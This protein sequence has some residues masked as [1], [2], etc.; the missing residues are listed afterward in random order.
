MFRP[1][2]LL[3]S[4][5]FKIEEEIR[6]GINANTL[7]EK[8]TL[9]ERHLRRLFKFAFKQT[10]AGYIR[11]R[12]LATSL[13]D[14]LMTDSN[15]LNIALEYNFEYEHTYIRSFKSEF[16]ITPGE[17]RKSG[18]IVRI[19][20][21]LYLLDENNLDGDLLFGPDIVMVPKFH[22]IGKKYRVPFTA[23]TAF[24]P[25]K[26]VEFWENER[27]N[28]KSVKD[29]N[30][31]IGIS[32]NV[33]DEHTEYLTSVQVSAIKNIPQ[34]LCAETFETTLCAR[35]R[36][37]GKLHYYT[38]NRN[39]ARALYSTIWDFFGKN[40]SGYTL[41]DEMLRFEKVDTRHYDGTYCQMEWYAPIKEMPKN[42]LKSKL[43]P[44]YYKSS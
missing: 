14:L 11:S 24:G 38:L 33:E 44:D 9:S 2:D 42:L 36:F 12:K 32:K 4:V 5:L 27:K 28:I 26:A 6:N 23:P 40:K 22:V 25:E 18:Q 29:Q 1:Y 31:Y 21:P 19:K 37:I 35:F 41:T 13:N 15:I 3:R 43:L 8:Y 30:L 34:G 39:T 7:S 10:L 20:P 16:G 17:L